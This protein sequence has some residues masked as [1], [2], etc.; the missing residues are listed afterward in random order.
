[1]ITRDE[2]LTLLSKGAIEVE[3]RVVT[4]SNQALLVTVSLDGVEGQACY[5]A[6]AGDRGARRR[7]LRDRI[8]AVVGRRQ[9]GGPLLHAARAPPVPRLVRR[10]GRLR[11]R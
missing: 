6:E 7:T 3:G 10:T 1:M 5:K 11:R 9:R 2:Q 8:A 4:S